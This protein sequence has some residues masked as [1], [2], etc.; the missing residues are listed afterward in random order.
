MSKP[1]DGITI[2]DLTRLLPG[3]ICTMFLADL[4]ANI[5]KIEDPILGDY[6][7]WTPPLINGQ[8]AFFLASNRNKRSVIL[9]LKTAQGQAT[10]QKMAQHA[11]VLIESFRPGVTARLG[12]D[13]ATLHALNPRLVY[14]SLSGWGQGGVYAEMSGHDLNYVA[15]SGLLGSMAQA[16]PLGGQIADVGGAYSGALGIASALFQREKTGMGDKIDVALFE[17]AMPFAMYQWVESTTGFSTGGTGSL[18]GGMAFYQVYQSAD[19]QPMAFAPIEPKFW[20]NFCTAVNRPD[21][22]PLHTD[23]S[24]QAY[25]KAE[26]TQLF[27]SESAQ[28]WHERLY[29]ADCCF[30]R[31]TPPTELLNDPQVRD[32]G[33]AGVDENGVAWMRS[34]LRVGTGEFAVVPA[35]QYG[36]HTEA[37]LGEMGFAEDEIATLK[38]QKAIGR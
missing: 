16:Q 18:T 23:L 4:G 20:E 17:A 8:G 27:A 12:V 10:L 19:G 9:N 5:I 38:A 28:T 24:Q 34:P 26:L 21:W 14:C 6:A 7:R 3:A 22:L 15:L 33:M 35:P 36:E 13:Y 37:I 32:R 25:L 2:L 11:D 31:I 30:T 29:H 1:L